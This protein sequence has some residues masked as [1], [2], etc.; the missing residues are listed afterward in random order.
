MMN[1]N[2]RMGWP[3][4]SQVNGEPHKLGL[5]DLITIEEITNQSRDRPTGTSKNVTSHP[6]AQWANHFNNVIRLVVNS[7][8]AFMV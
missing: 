1:A 8:P 5:Q 7:S 6:D 2:N 3:H 4:F